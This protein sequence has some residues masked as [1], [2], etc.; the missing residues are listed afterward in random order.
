MDASR[1]KA[2]I[3]KLT[4]AGYWSNVCRERLLS[5]WGEP[6]FLADWERVVFIHYEVN[7]A[8]LRKEVPFEIDMWQGRALVSLVAFTMRDMR[9]RRGGRLAA[10][11]FK[12]IA[13]HPF[14]NVRTYVKHGDERGI[15]FMTEWLPNRLSVLLGPLIYGLP[16]RFARINY[17]HAHEQGYLAGRIEA[18]G[19]GGS[20][21]YHAQLS[22]SASFTACPVDSPD[23]FL[24][25]RYTAFTAGGRTRRFFRIWHPPWWQ[26]PVQVLVTADSLLTKVWPWFK[27][28]RPVGANYS[29][30]FRDVWMGRAFCVN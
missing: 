11:P 15:Y 5:R 8:A 3:G 22:S 28:A 17:Q 27:D 7:A 20:L 16:Y 12:A 4:S 24:L 30:G 29:P 21:A 9:P 6:L 2:E 13:T 23:E 18:T 10:W 19:A 26:M 14:L 1:A 25:E